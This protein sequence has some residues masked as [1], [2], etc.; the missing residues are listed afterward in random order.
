MIQRERTGF[1]YYENEISQLVS[2]FHAF[3]KKEFY[4]LEDNNKNL[5][6][7]SNNEAHSLEKLSNEHNDVNNKYSKRKKKL[8]NYYKN[9]A[10][11]L[12]YNN[13]NK[14]EYKNDYSSNIT[15]YLFAGK[16]NLI[17]F[18][19]YY[20]RLIDIIKLLLNNNNVYMEDICLFNNNNYEIFNNIPSILIDIVLFSLEGC[21]FGINEIK[22]GIY[23]LKL[24]LSSRKYTSLFINKN[25]LESLYNLL[26][27][28]SYHEKFDENPNKLYFIE[29]PNSIKNLVLEIIYMIISYKEGLEKFLNGPIAEDKIH[30]K[31]FT[32][33]EL[34]PER[35]DF[36]VL[37]KNHKSYNCSR[38]N[39]NNEHNNNSNNNYKNN[40]YDFDELTSYNKSKNSKIKNSNNYKRNKSRSQSKYS[41]AS[42]INTNYISDESSNISEDKYNNNDNFSN[43]KISHTTRIANGYQVI[44]SLL[45]GR[46]TSNTT[47]II[48]KIIYKVSFCIYLKEIDYICK[49]YFELNKEYC[50]YDNIEDKSSSKENENNNNNNNRNFTNKEKE[51]YKISFTRFSNL[52]KN[53]L[54]YI[55]DKDIDYIKITEKEEENW[56]SLNYPYIHIWNSLFKLKHLF[57]KKIDVEYN[58]KANINTNNKSTNLN[59]DFFSN[60]L[61]ILLE[62]YNLLENVIVY[63]SDFTNNIYN[64]NNLNDCNTIKFN[65]NINDFTKIAYNFKTLISYILNMNGGI[66]FFSKNFDK[67][68]ALLKFLTINT[69]DLLLYNSSNGYEELV[70][71]KN[72]FSIEKEVNTNPNFIFENEIIDISNVLIY[73]N[74]NII[75]SNFS[76]RII[77]TSTNNIDL[78]DSNKLNYLSKLPKLYLYIKYHYLQLRYFIEE[79]FKV[80]YKI[81]NN[82]INFN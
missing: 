40:K 43:N 4:D 30:R 2:V 31:Y 73:K 36:I 21:K 25:G 45:A 38:N 32:I 15:E 18:N 82:V 65:Y 11:L 62:D 6:I 74:K 20:Q 16:L 48:Q 35:P 60:E 46:K 61:C 28:N 41:K 10:S 55:K 50:F 81:I 9:Y 34:N 27:N 71:Q 19:E 64:N 54:L 49:N 69:N 70:S 77:N 42:N 79:M 5:S 39:K 22:N 75:N 7:V 44:L 14:E 57:F 33:T 1:I 66:N 13:N 3:Y 58:I 23:L 59:N 67:T 12:Y 29:I 78:N 17:T 80:S 68:V 72:F 53:I 51:Y 47:S 24:L 56:Y 26:T 8:Y 37:N 63:L 76:S 52:I